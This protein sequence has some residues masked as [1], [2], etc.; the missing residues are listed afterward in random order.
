MFALKFGLMVYAI[1]ACLGISGIQAGVYIAIIGLFLHSFKTKVLF[2]NDD[3]SKKIFILIL[4]YICW[5]VLVSVFSAEK[6]V[7]FRRLSKIITEILLAMAVINL[8][9]EDLKFSKRLI[10]T[11]LFFASLQSV[12]G[13]LQYFT[14]V[15]FTHNTSQIPFTRIRGTLGYFNSLGGVLGMILPLSFS[16]AIFA[17][18]KKHRIL[19]STGAVLILMALMMTMTRGAWIGAFC[20][21]FFVLFQRYKW[22]T[23]LILLILPAFI[24]MKPVKN[25]IMD[26]L[27]KPESGRLFMWQKSF[28]MIKE[29]PI[30]GF[31]FD[32]FKKTFY[33]KYSGNDTLS[34]LS[35]EKGHFHPHNVLLTTMVESGLPGVAI[36]LVILFLILKYSISK[37]L[38]AGF[39]T[40]AVKIGITG[41]L[42]DF[43][44]HGMVDNVLRGETAYLFWFFV[45]MQFLLVSKQDIFKIDQMV[46]K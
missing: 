45:G 36:M 17:K 23:T 29:K 24:L 25:R 32:G 12:Y 40:T 34:K 9:R 18:N 37:S 43:I 3:S 41:G 5:G 27:T 14:G 30:V 19:Y 46:G 13:I 42:I 35:G 26:I 28:E 33:E 11:L 22:K 15:D 39:E 6:L 20:G 31:G 2:Y 16:C 1:F 4:I 7:S 10:N 44:L 38:C 21:V 8:S